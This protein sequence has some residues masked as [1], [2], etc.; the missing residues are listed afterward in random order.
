MTF[1]HSTISNTLFC[2]LLTSVSAKTYSDLLCIQA[3][4]STIYVEDN[5]YCEACVLNPPMTLQMC[6]VAFRYSE[7]PF[8]DKIAFKCTIHLELT[9]QTC[10]V[11][12]T[13]T[14]FH[15]FN[16][17]CIR[18]LYNPPMTA[19]MCIFSCNNPDLSRICR[20]CAIHPPADE[21]LCQY[22]C[23][24]K[25]VDFYYGRICSACS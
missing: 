10:M 19:D 4:L 8:F 20:K 15:H 18:C 16:K 2:L 1:L 5:T 25:T 11:A 22:A 24:K 14:N 13:N 7:S 23:E 21:K 6:A 9:D 17:I 3:C 12:C